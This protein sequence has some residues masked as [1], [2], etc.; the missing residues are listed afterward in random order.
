[1]TATLED[2]ARTHPLVAPHRDDNTPPGYEHDEAKDR[3]NFK[4][5]V[6]MVRQQN[7]LKEA[8]D[9]IEQAQV[10]RKLK[11]ERRKETERNTL[12]NKIRRSRKGKRKGRK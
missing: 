1:M 6:Q 4:K 2:I 5:A 9:R 7:K 8:R 11:E 10:Q 3:E 12:K